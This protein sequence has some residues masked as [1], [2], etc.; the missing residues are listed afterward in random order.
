M[1]RITRFRATVVVLLFALILGFYAFRLYDVQMIQ[2]G[3]KID[4]STTF[5]TLTRVKAARGDILDR[6][7]NVLVGNRASYDLV[8][9]HYVL[10][11]ANG[12]NQHL[13][14]LATRCKEQG[15]DY[16]EHFPISME[17]PFTYTLDEYNSAYQSYFQSYLV[18]MGDLDSDMTAPFL[19]QTLRERYELPAEWT[20]EE[21][22][23][24]IGLRYELALRNCV[25]S[26]AN[27]VFLTDASDQELSD[28]VE[29]NI[30]GMNVEASTVREY[31][32]K[33]AA[34]IL[35]FVGAMSPSQWE[36]YQNIEG[37]AMDAEVGQCGFEAAFEEYLHGTDGWREDTVS[38]DGTLVSSRYITEPKAGSNVEVTIDIRLQ[39]VAENAMAEVMADLK[40]LPEGTAGADAESCATVV[41]DV[42]TGQVL[43]C[44]SYPTY[45]LT[46]YFDHYA[47]LAKDPDAPLFNRALEAAFPPGSTFKMT[48]VVAAIDSGLLDA[49]TIIYADGMYDRDGSENDQYE[50]FQVSCLQYS[51]YG[52]IHGEVDASTALKVSCNYY[53]YWIGDRIRLSVMDDTAKGLGLGEP[54]GIE[55]PEEIGHRANEETKALL[56]EGNDA[57]WFQGDKILAAIG[58]SEHQFSPMQLCVYAATLANQGVRY[59]ATFL[60]RIVS[61]D[62]STLLRQSELKIISDL[63]I[64]DEAYQAYVDGMVRVTS[65]TG[66]WTGTG[67]EIFKNF[68]I[69]VAGKTGTATSGRLGS[70]NGAFVC[71][72]PAYAPEIAISVYGEKV[73]H[74]S[75]MGIVA[76]EILAAYFAVDDTVS[77]T[78][79][80][81]NQIG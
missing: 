12:T 8:L 24:V 50:N 33:Y 29:L 43:A 34:H 11:S 27:F 53:F 64:S 59:R 2:T 39:E 71:F 4:N 5:T 54:T 44:A 28:I 9:N 15:I 13:Y 56:H 20:D 26:M 18:Y 68:P 55:L 10:L 30:P 16:N 42:R 77:D 52:S 1:E 76:R 7:G 79:V 23:M 45:D 66:K 69:E 60:N 47:E 49:D 25:S 31:K 80:Y 19:I 21:A 37:Y 48:M 70:D 75:T 51:K 40:S 6:N 61:S 67:Y 35:G 17:R 14:N 22:R 58:Q 73:A 81:E 57:R 46:T 63:Q 36:Y 38:I 32:T 62:Y 65:E 41:M 78:V 72:A 3:G 74:G